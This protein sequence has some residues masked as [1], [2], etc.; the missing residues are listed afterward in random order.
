LRQTQEQGMEKGFNDDE[1]ADIMSEIENLEREFADPAPEENSVLQELA[2][3]PVEESVLQ[4]N[5]E[6]NKVLAMKHAPSNAPATM[7]F[8]VEGQMSV[9]LS[10]DV[11]GQSVSLS[12]SEE[13]LSITTDSGAKF[14][15]P[16]TKHEAAKKAA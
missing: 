16:M 11:N 3:K 5:H 10:F 7:S 15:L 8:K 6:E 14:T 2:H 1:L 4:T 13:G 9:E 12:V